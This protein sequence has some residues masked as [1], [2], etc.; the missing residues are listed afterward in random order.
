MILICI[1]K[2]TYLVRRLLRNHP[3]IEK[4]LSQSA[5]CG[6]IPCIFNASFLIGSSPFFKSTD[7][8][9]FI[10]VLVPSTYGSSKGSSLFR[11]K[12]SCVI[13][14]LELFIPPPHWI[15][16]IL[17]ASLTIVF[18]KIS[19]WKQDAKIYKMNILLKLLNSNI[20]NQ[21]IFLPLYFGWRK[22]ASI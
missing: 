20:N 10:G 8:H 13:K 15:F 11:Y 22:N 12:P 21:S 1:F 18:L 17:I 3:N 14:R 5:L 16:Q 6:I 7:A 2:F 4:T 9:Q 19:C